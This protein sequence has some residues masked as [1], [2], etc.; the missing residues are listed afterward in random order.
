V[1]G[2]SSSR[3]RVGSNIDMALGFESA[4]N[5]AEVA[6]VTSAFTI[7]LS[8]SSDVAGNDVVADSTT[9]VEI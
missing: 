2:G 4:G 3:H 1:S 9:S 8:S 7:S 6:Y 5:E